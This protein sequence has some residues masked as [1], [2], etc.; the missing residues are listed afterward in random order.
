MT[1]TFPPFG[2]AFPIL[3]ILFGSMV[4]ELGDTSAATNEA[5]GLSCEVQF[6]TKVCLHFLPRG[7]LF[8][9]KLTV[10]VLI[11]GYNDVR[12]CSPGH[13]MLSPARSRRAA[14]ILAK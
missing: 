9:A 3:G 10:L 11:L 6:K 8:L 1:L 13:T 12:G 14:L 4:L 5:T 7:I 2:P